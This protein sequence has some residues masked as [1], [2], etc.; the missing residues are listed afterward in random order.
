MFE[1]AQLSLSLIPRFITS[2]TT[3]FLVSDNAWVWV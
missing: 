3:G 2:V 1:E